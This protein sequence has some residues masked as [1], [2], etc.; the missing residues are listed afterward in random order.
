MLNISKSAV[1]LYLSLL[2]SGKEPLG[3]SIYKLL[4]FNT[5]L[6]LMC[7]ASVSLDWM[8]RILVLLLDVISSVTFSRLS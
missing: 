8:F 4:L 7:L 6:Q 3:S 1:L 2:P 5:V